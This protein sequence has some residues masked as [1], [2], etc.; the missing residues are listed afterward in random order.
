MERYHPSGSS[1][2][3]TSL[4]AHPCNAYVRSLKMQFL[5]EAEIVLGVKEYC[6]AEALDRNP[7]QTRLFRNLDTKCLLCEILWDCRNR[8]GFCLRDWQRWGLWGA[9]RDLT[10]KLECGP[11][12]S[13]SHSSQD[14]LLRFRA[15][16]WAV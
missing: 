9:V 6:G 1:V 7:L 8:E 11:L 13:H 12:N 4:A 5:K 3:R 16:F 10:R 2:L 14:V 15:Q